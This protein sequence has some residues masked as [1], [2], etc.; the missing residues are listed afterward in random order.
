MCQE[1]SFIRAPRISLSLLQQ[2]TISEAR[3]ELTEMIGHDYILQI[4][5]TKA[6]GLVVPSVSHAVHPPR[7]MASVLKPNIKGG[8]Q[9]WFLEGQA[10]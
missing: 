3:R 6:W 7:E 4:A 1:H 10:A 2:A 9:C 8:R 5:L